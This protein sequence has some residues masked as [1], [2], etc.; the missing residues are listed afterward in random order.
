MCEKTLISEICCVRNAST[1]G[2]RQLNL[3]QSNFGIGSRWKSRSVW[4]NKH[5]KVDMCQFCF[6][7]VILILRHCLVDR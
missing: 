7:P 5:D 2:R 6:C 1:S 4:Y 3:L